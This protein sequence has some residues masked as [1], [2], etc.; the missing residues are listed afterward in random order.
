[1]HGLF[2]LGLACN[3]NLATYSS[4]QPDEVVGGVGPSPDPDPDRTPVPILPY[5]PVAFDFPKKSSMAN[6]PH[7]SAPSRSLKA[8]FINKKNL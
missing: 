6:D 1:M 3:P 7:A 5:V 4:R 8:I 2:P